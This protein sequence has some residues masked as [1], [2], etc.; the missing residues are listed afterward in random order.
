MQSSNQRRD[1]VAKQ[2]T[3]FKSKS[4]FKSNMEKKMQKKSKTYQTGKRS[5]NI[6]KD[7]PRQ[8]PDKEWRKR[9]D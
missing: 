4:K 2:N 8:W 5:M 6:D 9:T 7:K 1:K 3:K